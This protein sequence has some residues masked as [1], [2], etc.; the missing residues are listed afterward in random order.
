M[1]TG[2]YALETGLRLGKQG[3]DGQGKLPKEVALEAHSPENPDVPM[4]EAISQLQELTTLGEKLVTELKDPPLFMFS[5][6]GR[7]IDVQIFYDYK[8]SLTDSHRSRG[9]SDHQHLSLC[10]LGGGNCGYQSQYPRE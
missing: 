10:V 9:S 8:G 7:Y 2:N 5:T 4:A 6:S 3:Q 1:L